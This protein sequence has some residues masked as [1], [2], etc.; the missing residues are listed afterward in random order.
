[1]IETRVTFDLFLAFPIPSTD[2]AVQTLGS[3]S[4]TGACG[5]GDDLFGFGTDAG[6]AF[7]SPG[8]PHRIQS[9]TAP[10]WGRRSLGHRALE[11]PNP[12]P[13]VFKSRS[14]RFRL[15]EP[16]FGNLPTIFPGKTAKSRKRRISRVREKK[17]HEK[18]KSYKTN[19]RWTR[20]SNE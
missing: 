14:G 1:L 8:K 20:N 2:H 7:S 18:S 13:P 9:G 17:R 12:L 4:F 3:P 5:A 15:V 11:R 6:A 16:K 10:R 19:I